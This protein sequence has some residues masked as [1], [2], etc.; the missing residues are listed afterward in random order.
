MGNDG[1]DE[2]TREAECQNG[3]ARLG[4]HRHIPEKGSCLEAFL[5]IGR[6]SAKREIVIA[7]LL[8]SRAG[9]NFLAK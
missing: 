8:A 4:G 7:R 1:L 3:L 9:L 5:A 6:L 2:K